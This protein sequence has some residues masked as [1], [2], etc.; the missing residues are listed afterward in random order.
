M[1]VWMTSDGAGGRL[2]CGREAETSQRA[3][4]RGA[5]GDEVRG[6]CERRMRMH[7]KDEFRVS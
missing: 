7:K 3:G 6:R 4:G 2:L 5:R 1:V